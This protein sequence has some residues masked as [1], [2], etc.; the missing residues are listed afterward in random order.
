MESGACLLYDLP[1][2]VLPQLNP[3]WFPAPAPSGIL[4]TGCKVSGM[5]WDCAIGPHK[6]RKSNGL[7]CLF[8]WYR[9]RDYVT[10]GSS[11]LG[12]CFLCALVSLP[13]S[14][15]IGQQSFQVAGGMALPHFL[16]FLCNSVFGESVRLRKMG[17][18][19]R[20]LPVTARGLVSDN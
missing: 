13:K 17:K 12:F 9:S 15:G 10:A 20:P 14:P 11:V 19:H 3:G 4:A 16:M 6:H 2:P 5:N 18:P 1:S 8:V 7:T